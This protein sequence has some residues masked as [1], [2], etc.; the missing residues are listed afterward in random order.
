MTLGL[1]VGSITRY[2][3]GDW[4]SID[5]VSGE[6]V[7]HVPPGDAVTDPDL[8][9]DVVLAWQRSLVSGLAGRDVTVSTWDEGAGTAYATAQP[10]WSGYGALMLLAAYDD[11]P[12]LS[13]P[14]DA[15]ERWRESPAHRAVSAPDAH[16]RYPAL[17][18]GAEW[19][20]PGAFSVGFDAP[21]PS[22]AHVLM[23]S[24][25]ALRDQLGE[26]DQRTLRL[27]DDVDLPV[28]PAGAGFEQHACY[29]LATFRRLAAA[30]AE[31]RLPMLLDY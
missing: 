9:R 30:A 19:W 4:V 13:S 24:V 16:T 10:G 7:H 28:P 27:G 15:A 8:V 22:G 5:P 14:D 29:G 2:L 21:T 17:V 11:R 1:Y 12:D 25:E 3:T 18:K 20:L 26:L 31:A 6:T 23:A